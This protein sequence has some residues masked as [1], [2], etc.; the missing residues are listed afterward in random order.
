[1]RDVLLEW[2]ENETCKKDRENKRTVS[3]KTENAGV[4]L[5]ARNTKRE[6]GSRFKGEL[7]RQYRRNLEMKYG[8][9][10]PMR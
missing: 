7:T 2:G 8:A 9:W 10:I 6:R 3:P 1:M 5:G 4:R